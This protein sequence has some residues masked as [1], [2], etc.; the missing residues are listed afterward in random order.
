MDIKAASLEG[1][2]GRGTNIKENF[3]CSSEKL[4]PLAHHANSCIGGRI[5]VK[6]QPASTSNIGG[7]KVR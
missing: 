6:I 7:S 4:I 1:S 2:L 3:R 5:S